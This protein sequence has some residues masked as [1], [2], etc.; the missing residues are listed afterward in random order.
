MD[1]GLVD[2]YDLTG[3]YPIKFNV[4]PVG[5]GE[6]EINSTTPSTYVF[7]GDY[8]GGIDILLD[9]N[10]NTGYT[11]SHWEIFNHTL[12]S[13]LTNDKNSLQ[14]TQVDSIVAHFIVEDSTR[15]AFDVFPLGSG[16]I[17]ID[18]FV[19]PSYVHSDYYPTL[20]TLD[21]IAVP[22]P[23]YVFD[24][25]ESLSTTFSPDSLNPTVEITV[26]LLDSI[27]AHFVIVE[28]FDLIYNVNPVGGGDVSIN[29]IIPGVY[30]H[31]ETYNTN[32]IVALVAIPQTGYIFDH[33]E[34][35]V[36]GFNPDEFTTNATITVNADDSII[37][38]FL[39]VDTFDITYSVSPIGTGDVEVN[40]F[41]PLLYPYTE[42]YI[43]NT[44]VNLFEYELLPETYSFDHWESKNHTI[45]PSSASALV[46]FNV[47]AD[48]TII[49]VY[50]EIPVPPTQGAHLPGAFS[51]NGDGNNDILFVYGGQIETIS[52]SI[53]DR[54]GE[55]V[56]QTKDETEGWDGTYKGKEA[57]AGVYV[58]KM[59]V[60]YWEGDIET[61][62]GNITLIR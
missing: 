48:D 57:S 15:L 50:I 24:Y 45:L 46:N 43:T 18:G 38:H 39:Y 12:D 58:Y 22:Q 28:T 35:S 17:D 32:D 2:C 19:P 31:Y 37:A 16:D 42:S 61:K 4:T 13:A 47:L 9:A 14:I 52:I 1:D 34:S 20:S 29:T 44:T 33:W 53:Y 6:I 3:P 40:A 60:S 26:D 51:P 10:S 7:I 55:L 41:V 27:V 25:W 30:P 36:L 56:W 23:G 21:L 5:S 59:K 11:F 49:A 62:A 54:W 8:F